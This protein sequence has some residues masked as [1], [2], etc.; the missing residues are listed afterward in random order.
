MIRYDYMR[1]RVLARQRKD[2]MSTSDEFFRIIGQDPTLY[3]GGGIDFDSM[4]PEAGGIF[5]RAE[6]GVGSFHL[7]LGSEHGSA[8]YSLALDAEQLR[9]IS[10]AARASALAIEAY[11]TLNGTR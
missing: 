10:V 6:H 3:E 8:G 4:E 2:E 7:N 11:E 9:D 5:I 1:A